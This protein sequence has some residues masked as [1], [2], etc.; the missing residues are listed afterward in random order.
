MER[1]NLNQLLEANSE[2][3]PAGDDLEYD[4][5]FGE[6]ERTAKGREEQQLGDTLIAAEAPDWSALRSHALAVLERSKDLRAA[7]QLTRALIQTDGYH[8]LADGLSLIKGYLAGY[9][10]SLY[11]QLDPDDHN[12]PTIRVNTLLNLCD[13]TEFLLPV[14]RLPL[15]TSPR[16]GEISY[17]HIQIANGDI[18]FPESDQSSLTPEQIEAGFR[19]ADSSQLLSNRKH[20]GQCLETIE[21]IESLVSQQLNGECLFDLQPLRKLLNAVEQELAKYS[22]S[23]N[24]AEMHGEDNVKGLNPTLSAASDNPA[25][26][27]VTCRDDVIRSLDRICRYYAQY[28][29]S[30]PVPL[31][32][33]RAKRLVAMDFHEIVQ[34]LAPEG[35]SHFDF[36]WR[37][38]D[39]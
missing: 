18:P 11:P 13:T 16:L 9:W 33:Q 32:L 25:S 24:P 37:Q 23:E 21:E 10:E 34:D 27:T 38:G 36:L 17:R 20:I 1:I 12:D 5:L 30:S 3:T 15:L 7:V 35:Q 22:L 4:P 31:L 8:G 6:M 2:E 14:T 28:E 29:P 19:H 39:G 26:G